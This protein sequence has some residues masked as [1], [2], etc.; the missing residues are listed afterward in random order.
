MRTR[1]LVFLVVL[2]C[3]SLLR[4]VDASEVF[5]Q[6][7]PTFEKE[8]AEWHPIRKAVGHALRTHSLSAWAKS[9]SP[10]PKTQDPA[11]LLRDAIV[12]ALAGHH[13]K[14]ERRLGVLVDLP[15][16]F[17]R[18]ELSDLVRFLDHR[19]LKRH[20]RTVM[21][22]APHAVGVTAGFFRVWGDE[23]GADVVDRWL[24]ARAKDLE[25]PWLWI[26][27]RFRK[28]QGTAEPLVRMLAERV[29]ANP[30][31][32]AHIF[33]YL[34]GEGIL[35]DTR[36]VSWLE[37][38]AR[39]R[40]AHELLK[41]GKRLRP[42]AWRRT[43]IHF[44]ERALETPLTEADF[45]VYEWHARR[46]TVE[47]MK[48]MIL[49]GIKVEL[50]DAYR[51]AGRGE[52]AQALL[53]DLAAVHPDGLPRAVSLKSAGMVQRV[54]G[55]RVI[56]KRILEQEEE[57]KDS[58]TYWIK[59]GQYYAGRK[60]KEPA[61]AAFRKA[62]ALAPDDA[63][64]ERS[65]VVREYEHWLRTVDEYAALQALLWSE[66]E[67][68]PPASDY[69][70]WMIA[71][72]VDMSRDARGTWPDPDD[73]RL[74]RFLA[75]RP[76]WRHPRLLGTM[77]RKADGPAFWDRARALAHGEPERVD[78]L[79]A[80]MLGAEKYEMAVPVLEYALKIVP[81]DRRG[82]VVSDLYRAY[83]WLGQWRSA[84]SLWAL[85]RARLRPKEEAVG[86]GELAAA[87]AKGGNAAAALRFWRL[88]CNQDLGSIKWLPEMASA[89]MRA[90]LRSFYEAWARRDPASVHPARMLEILART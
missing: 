24:A 28:H 88:R 75:A 69:A 32:L 60:E 63:S 13:D 1:H 55:Y 4:G 15:P 5:V 65:R 52:E 61:W 71:E 73:K 67:R 2:A 64:Y 57:S 8:P 6:S 36:D 7:P 50:M 23:A 31:S 17:Q 79:G 46:P 20:A 10:E 62:L 26:R 90:P 14:L 82:S 72:F 37:E 38:V 9:I 48:A 59:R 3:G 22:H 83:L 76:S 54:S 39:P 44:L 80:V 66:F 81:E 53:E 77:A 33:A 19:G 74:W 84:E 42:H 87:A 29:R 16:E 68:V 45:G 27:L 86:L 70:K 40:L 58:A 34:S 30:T 21:E 41:L 78:V 56:E 11:G 18:R 85:Q 25:D 12:L 43:Q 35:D 51:R 47:R 89:G 49:N